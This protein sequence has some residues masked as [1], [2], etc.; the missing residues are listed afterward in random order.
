MIN[1]I[2]ID[3]EPLALEILKG[4]IS[5]FNQ[6][7]LVQVFDDGIAGQSFLQANK[8]DLLFIDINMPDITGL[9]LLHIK[10]L[11]LMVLSWMR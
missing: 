2:A 8:V 1:C 6:L 5:K 7:H 10:N 9:E 3:D 11:P 4:Y